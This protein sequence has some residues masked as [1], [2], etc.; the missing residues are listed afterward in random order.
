MTTPAHLS[1]VIQQ[2]ATFRWRRRW[3]SFPKPVRVAG[4]A[5][6]Y[7]DTGNPAPPED[8]VPTDFTGCTARMQLRADIEAP[9]VL[10]EF[11]TSPTAAQGHI[12]LGADGWVE[13]ELSDAQAA[14]LPYGQGLGQWDSAEGQLDVTFADG[15]V[16]RM[17]RV[18]VS[19]CPGGNRD[20]L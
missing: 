13:L 2:G 10:L 14:A 5:V 8:F 20:A 18:H 4:C 6:I 11:S 15:T 17:A 9:D 12:V 7:A 19:L 16:V 1:A 3:G